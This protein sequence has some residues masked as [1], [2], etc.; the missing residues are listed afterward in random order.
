MPLVAL[1]PHYE[2]PPTTQLNWKW[3]VCLVLIMY[4]A[5]LS[6]F[7]AVFVQR[8]PAVLGHLC[9]VT[10]LYICHAVFSSCCVWRWRE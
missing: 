6:G 5:I 10:V 7:G 8:A 3:I 1:G 2:E 4:D 9:V